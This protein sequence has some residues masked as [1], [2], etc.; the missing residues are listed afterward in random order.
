M[1][2]NVKEFET[3]MKRIEEI[4]ATLEKGGLALSDSLRLYE[5]GISAIKNC[6]ETLKSAKLEIE[7]V[8]SST[9]DVEKVD[10]EDGEEK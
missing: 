9:G 3:D 6:M 5:E 1:K 4:V 8:G 7:R 10:L 2:R